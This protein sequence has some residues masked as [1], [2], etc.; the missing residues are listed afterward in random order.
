M[1]VTNRV[2]SLL[3]VPRRVTTQPFGRLRGGRQRTGTKVSA[4][5]ALASRHTSKVKEGQGCVIPRTAESHQRSRAPLGGPSLQT[6]HT[7]ASRSLH[8]SWTQAN[9][10]TTRITVLASTGPQVD[11][12]P[13]FPESPLILERQD[14]DYLLIARRQE[15]RQ[16]EN[17][18]PEH[19]QGPPQP[20]PQP[21]LR[22]SLRIKAIKAIKDAAPPKVKA[23]AKSTGR[24]RAVRKK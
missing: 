8:R 16:D 2:A 14:E 12:E 4:M 20:E 7:G 21:E 10:I 1:V 15:G 11:I 24:K 13:V 9:M 18:E 17:E 5:T 3:E 23:P 22:R 6:P 19:D